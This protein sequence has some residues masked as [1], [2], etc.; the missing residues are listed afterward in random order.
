METEKKT[1]GEYLGLIII[2][3]ILI[4]GGI[5]I[6]QSQIKKNQEIKMQN[7]AVTTQNEN[8]VK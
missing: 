4:V 3:I 1:S 8:I 7:S 2:I 6:W 5:Y